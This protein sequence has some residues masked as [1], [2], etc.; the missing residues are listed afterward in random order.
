MNESNFKQG[1]S[2]EQ[3]LSHSLGYEGLVNDE[4]RPNYVKSYTGLKD[5]P[6]YDGF[7]SIDEGVNWAKAHPN[8]LNNPTPENT[9]YNTA[10]LDFGCLTVDKIGI[11]NTERIMPVNLFTKFNTT[12]FLVND[13]LRATVYASGA[14]DII[15]QNPI[16]H[17]ISIVNNNATNYDWNGGSF[18]RDA[19]IQLERTR[20]GL[21]NSHGFKNYYYDIGQ[22]RK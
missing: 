12:K 21:S 7:V 8:A 19:T 14:V 5:G 1:M 16:L 11:R 22:L 20:T 17:I 13:R 9:L 10:L 15:L 18:I 4:A 6:D 3:A 2:H